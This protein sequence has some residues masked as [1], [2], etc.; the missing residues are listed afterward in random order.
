MTRTAGRPKK[1]LFERGGIYYARL[2]VE[3]KRYKLSTGT[4]DLAE[5]AER[6]KT[7]RLYKKAWDKIP[8][9]Y[10]QA[11]RDYE[12]VKDREQ[13]EAEAPSLPPEVLASDISRL[14]DEE[15]KLKVIARLPPATL[16]YWEGRYKQ[17]KNFLAIH[18][19]N[20]ETFDLKAALEYVSYR[21]GRVEGQ[22]D[23]KKKK[24]FNNRPCKIPTIRKEIGLFRNLWDLWR[25][26]GKVGINPWGRVP[27]QKP[28]EA[29]E[30]AP[31]PYTPEDLKK[32]FSCIEN[33][34]VRNLLIFQAM[35]GTRPG[36]ETMEITQEM[37]DAGKVWSWKKRRLDDYD[38]SPQAK[39]WFKYNIEGKLEGI[40]PAFVDKCFKKACKKAEV[41]VGKAYDLRHTFATEA[42]KSFKLET[43]SAAIRHREVKTTQIYAVIRDKEAKEAR[44]AMQ[45]ELLAKITGPEAF[46]V[47]GGPE[48]A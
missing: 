28:T 27:V 43:V 42:L 33:E 25:D 13:K 48:T 23:T 4:G 38:Y 21:L 12:R 10:K 44:E 1:E 35:L 36:V 26:D 9:K 18:P 5:A 16:H 22:E 39:A 3:G 45:I 7:I 30:A 40:T 2:N 46:P 6:L 19:Y 29:T 34:P 24:G 17:M 31:Q 47:S 15:Y 8:E 41:R 14:L 20:L 11:V 37:I 32:I